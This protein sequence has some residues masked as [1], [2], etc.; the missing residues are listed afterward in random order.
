[1]VSGL[2]SPQAV[3][4]AEVLPNRPT[5]LLQRLS[6]SSQPRLSFRIVGGKRREHTDAPYSLSLL[7]TGRERPRERRRAE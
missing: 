4:E 1:M 6:E 3:I 2:P 5:R 7:R